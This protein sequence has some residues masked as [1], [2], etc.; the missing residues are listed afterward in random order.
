MQVYR[1]SPNSELLQREVL[2]RIRQIQFEP[3]V[4]RH[5]RVGVWIDGTIN[6]FIAD[7]KPHLR[8]LLNQEEQDLKH[9][10]DFIA[11]QYAFVTGNPKF[12]GIYWPPGAPGHE[13]TAAVMMDIDAT[14][15]VLSAK[16]LFEHPPGMG[17]GAAVTGSV[18][19]AL[20]IPGFRSGKRVPCR[21]TW[22]VM[23]FGPGL[24]MKSG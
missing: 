9:G 14:G 13:G 16:V 1:T 15:R 7:G 2:G 11:P 6:F 17:F 24:Q 12:Q 3:A 22:P 23:F 10:N 4:Y 5:N 20:F 8:I 21:F 18:R 19:D